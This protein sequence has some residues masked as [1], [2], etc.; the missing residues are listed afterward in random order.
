MGKVYRMLKDP[1]GVWRRKEGTG[2]GTWFIEYRDAAGKRVRKATQARTKSEAN[3][4]LRGKEGDTVKA[5]IL[6]VQS[7]DAI[8]LTLSDYLRKT[9][10]PHVRLTRRAGTADNYEAYA[11]RLISFYGA[12]PL[13]SLGRADVQRYIDKRISEGLTRHKRPIAPATV[14]R[15]TAFLRS[16]LY[17]A[18]A[19]GYIDRNPCARIKLLH[20]ENTRTRV[21]TEK[22]E[23]RLLKHSPDWLRPVIQAATLCGLRRGELLGL[24]WA[25]IDQDRKLVFVSAESKSHK[26]REVPIIPELE[27]LLGGLT[28]AIGKDGREPF[29]FIDASSKEALKADTVAAAF[30]RAVRNADIRDLHFHDLRRTFASRLAQKG[31]SLQMIAKLLGHGATYVTE[32]YAHLSADDAREAMAK[33]SKSPVAAESGRFAA[34]APILKAAGE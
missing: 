13:R 14:N 17:E 7:T 29:V 8:R 18:L 32:R 20:E 25:D 34:D 9:Y 4:L 6:G 27:A 1:E 21:M 11:E 24:R 28:Q 22:E 30:E 12:V 31:V 5:E 33:L 10:L 2:P 3:L 15:E 16:A 26:G 23:E 19:R